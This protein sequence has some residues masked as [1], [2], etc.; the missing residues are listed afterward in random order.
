MADYNDEEIRAFQ[1]TCT[2]TV[3]VGT[4]WVTTA[5]KVIGD[6]AKAG[7]GN[8]EVNSPYNIAFSPDGTTGYVADTGN[9][10]IG[11]YNVTSCNGTLNGQANECA[12]MKNYGSRCPTPCP[13]PPNN[14]ANFNA[15]RR[16]TGRIRRP[17]I[18]G[19]LT[20]GKW[21]RRVSTRTGSTTGMYE[22]DGSPAPAKGFAEAYGVAVGPDGTTYVADR[23]NER[24]E[25]F[26]SNGNYVTEQGSRGV[27]VGQ[28]SWPEAVT[29]TPDKTVWVGDTRNARLQHFTNA[30]L[31]D[32]PTVVGAKGTAVGQFNYIEGVSAAAN[33]VVWVADTDNNRVQS[34]NPATQAFAAFG[35]KGSA[36]NTN[37]LLNPESVVASTTNMY[38][39]DTGNNRVVK[40]DLNGN[41]VA[42]YTGLDEPQGIAL[43]PD[44]SIWVANTGTGSQTPTATT[45]FTSRRR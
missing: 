18:S 37:Q 35:T 38:I 26:D 4:A 32:K 34:Y 22:I 17:A 8:G 19:R 13:A 12:F 30:N 39:A 11:V 31:T 24:I 33:G 25:E 29:V 1:C 42:S 36:P 23:L 15:L 27:A 10:R 21:H 2:S 6:G 41:Y 16:V 20:S 28:Y 40:L 5:N 43:A 44:G 14:A 3:K 7:H 9:E 45:S